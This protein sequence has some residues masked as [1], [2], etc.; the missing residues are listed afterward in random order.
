MGLLVI[1]EWKAETKPLDEKN[2]YVRIVGRKKGFWSWLLSKFKID[3]TI[4]MFVNP[5]WIEFT[6]FSMSGNY[7]K[8]INLDEVSSTYYGFTKPWAKTISIFFTNMFLLIGIGYEFFRED[9]LLFVLGSMIFSFFVAILYYKYNKIFVL[10]FVASSGE[11]NEISFKRSYIENIEINEEQAK[12]V[13]YIIQ[14]LIEF[15]HRRN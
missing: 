10:G 1:K 12:K 14:K 6:A 4:S 7:Y 11:R 2:N 13:C 5:S 8:Y 15:K 9:L 3:P